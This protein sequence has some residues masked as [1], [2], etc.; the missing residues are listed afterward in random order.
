MTINGIYEAAGL[1]LWL[2]TGIFEGKDKSDVRVDVNWQ[3]L[4]SFKSAW[5]DKASAF[6]AQAQRCAGS[7]KQKLDKATLLWPS[8]MICAVGSVKE[9]AQES[10]ES[11]LPLLNNGKFVL[12]AWYLAL[13]E[14]L[15]L[16]ASRLPHSLSCA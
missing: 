4:K 11:S 10:F 12:W 8:E 14:A 13:F 1:A 2:Q 9:A 3:S 15:C 16:K 5:F 6:R 7:K